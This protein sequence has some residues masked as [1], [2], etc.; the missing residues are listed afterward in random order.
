V[1][2]KLGVV[3]GDEREREDGRR[4][5]LNYGHT[6]G[7][8]LETVTGYGQWLHGEAVAVGMA[9]AA[10]VGQRLGL[11]PPAVVARQDALLAAFGLPGRL[12][13]IPATRLMR[14]ALWDK[15]VRGGRVRWIVATDLGSATAVEDVPDEVVRAVLV[16]LGARVAPDTEEEE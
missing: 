15:K 10:R 6:I 1:A 8:A 13:P 5:L 14:A 16:E 7:H 3:Q 4:Q 11:T 9:V 2:L 12:P